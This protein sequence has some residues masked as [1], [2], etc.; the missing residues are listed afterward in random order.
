LGVSSG[1]GTPGGL[2][3]GR[4]LIDSV[5]MAIQ[6][7]QLQSNHDGWGWSKPAGGIISLGN[8]PVSTN[9]GW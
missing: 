2:S 1:G 3:K 9:I 5:S 4:S 8:S 6:V 7:H